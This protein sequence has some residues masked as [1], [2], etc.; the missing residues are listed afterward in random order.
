MEI[1]TGLPL[2]AS[3]KPLPSDTDYPPPPPPSMAP[4]RPGPSLASTIIRR[5]Q[6]RLPREK[7]AT[8]KCL[9]CLMPK[10]FLSPQD[11]NLAAGFILVHYPFHP[12]EG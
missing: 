10:M 7:E 12:R 2:K 11:I 5:L 8:S 4:Q 3:C 9:A 1:P 6:P